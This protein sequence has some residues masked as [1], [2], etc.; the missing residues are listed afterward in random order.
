MVTLFTIGF[1]RKSAAE[2]FEGLQK[3]GV[4]KIIDTR[5]N[6]TSQ[7]S[8]FAKQADLQYFLKKIGNIDY[9]HQLSLAPTKDILDA[10][11]KKSISW[12]EYTHRY[13]ALIQQRQVES[14]LTPA[15]LQ[16]ACFLCSEDQPHHC[17]RRLAAEYLQSHLPDIQVIHV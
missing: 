4:R 8:G 3:A 7:L 5:L 2:F 15:D 13:L 9:E 12:E 1:T 14:I 17:H 11:K 6:N 10:Y 16:D